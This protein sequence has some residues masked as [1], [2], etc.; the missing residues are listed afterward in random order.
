MRWH[1]GPL[2]TTLLETLILVT[3][4][5]YAFMLWQEKRLP[6][7]TPY[8][9]WIALWL[10]AGA[11]GVVVAPSLRSAAGTYRAY[12][13]EA[14]AMYYIAVDLLRTRDDLRRFFGVTAL[15]AIGMSVGG[16]VLFAIVAARHQIQLGDAPTFLYMTPNANAMYLEPPLAF[17][18]A[19]VAFGWSRRQRLIAGAV[20]AIVFV[21]MLLTLSRGG[22]L[23]MAALALVLI[24]YL[25]SRRLR[26]YT[27][28][29]LALAVFLVLEVPFIRDR[30]MTAGASALLR[31]SIYG[32]ALKM[33]VQRPLF[34]AGIDG[35]TIRVKPFH[36]PAESVELYPHNLW[37]TTWSEVGLLGL[38][39]VTAL[40]FILLWRGLRA[41]RW[42][43]EL[44]RPVLW[45]TV[46]SVVMIVVHGLFDSPLWKNDL[47][48]EFWLIVALQVVAIRGAKAV[49]R[50]P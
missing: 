30:L 42:T 15:G 17:A 29:G 26:L 20:L 14:V 9:V 41:L 18:L 22:Y 35:F 27:A 24:V 49:T 38:I 11:I 1:Y 6:Q 50:S 46:G 40:L 4:A 47:S 5:G 3:V 31:N 37:L 39:V 32:Q 10:V 36:P 23:A 34:G 8:D 44:F 19:F 28:G 33:L 7:R 12:F 25:P 21:E 2:P 13:V 16:I 48:V 43:D 45:G